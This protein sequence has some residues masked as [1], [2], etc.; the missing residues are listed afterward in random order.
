MKVV[1][2]DMFDDILK[3]GG[4]QYF[5]HKEET[6]EITLIFTSGIQQVEPGDEDC[7]GRIWNPPVTDANGNPLLDWNGNVREPW[8][9]FEAQCTIGG[10]PHVYSFSGRKSSVLKNMIMAM[11]MEEISNDDLPGTKWTIDRI[12][13]WDWVIKLLGRE[14]DVA[15]SPLPKKEDTK[16]SKINP[17]IIEALKVKKDQTAGGVPK[18]DLFAYLSLVSHMKADELEKEWQSFIDAN[19]IKEKEGKV[20][21]V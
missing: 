18:G 3:E 6:G 10:V 1:T 20:F 11:K 5:F 15:S 16:K 21:I 4:S 8:A 19:L 17:T 9:K 13:K 12:G 7:I 14:D 2:N